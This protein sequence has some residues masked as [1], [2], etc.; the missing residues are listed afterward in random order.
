MGNLCG[1]GQ[2]PQQRAPPAPANKRAP[3]TTLAP[4]NT[5]RMGTA[6]PPR[7][8]NAPYTTTP[9]YP[10]PPTSQPG[11]RSISHPSS[12][13]SSPLPPTSSHPS[14]N[15]SNVGLPLSSDLPT[16]PTLKSPLNDRRLSLEANGASHH[17]HPPSPSNDA[18]VLA[19][20]GDPIDS[21][22]INLDVRVDSGGD[23][24]ERFW[25]RVAGGADNKRTFR[26]V[27]KAGEVGGR[28][29]ARLGQTIRATMRATLGGGDIMETVKLP[30]GEDLN[31]WIAVNSQRRH[32]STRTALHLPP[33]AP[34]S[35]ASLAVSL[36]LL[37][38]CVSGAHLQRCHADLGHVRRVLHARELSADDRRSR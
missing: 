15:H 1:S 33:L 20:P 25:M 10:P 14:P 6:T 37:S 8:V 28:G 17:H 9:S 29:G 5:V 24:A 38:L 16:I 34:L 21:P 27:E 18:E 7:V 2:K 26:Q 36:L 13:P 12:L 11:S 3:V 22:A 23:A 30:P 35:P 4:S 19:T 31:E 32:T